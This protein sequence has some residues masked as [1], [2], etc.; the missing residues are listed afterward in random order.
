MPT[1]DALDRPASRLRVRLG[2]AL[3]RSVPL[4][5][6]LLASVQPACTSTRYMTGVGSQAYYQ[7]AWPL[8]DTSRQIEEIF[9][10]VKRIQVTGYYETFQFAPEDRVTRAAL[11]DADTYRRA[12]DRFAFDH[13]KAGTATAIARADRALHLMTNAHVTRM[14]DTVV[15]YFDST[16]HNGRFIES[17]AILRSQSNVIV[18]VPTASQFRVIA[19]DTLDDIALLRVELEPGVPEHAVPALRARAGDPG[20]LSW[21]SFVYVV[22]YPRGHMMVTRAIVSNPRQSSDNSF[23]LD[24]LFNR[25]ISGG[26]VL[27][28]RGD[29]GDLEWVGLAMS[30]SAHA[31][32]VLAPE[33]RSIDEQGVLLPYQGRLF[34]EEVR[35]IDYGITF[36]VPATAVT[37]FLRAA[38][39]PVSGGGPS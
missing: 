14:Q 1:P 16:A 28:V 18:G 36:S 25:G 3:R 30:A 7:T 23:M 32:V 8:H 39:M 34:I 22:G 24:G 12:R 26:L 20:R 37:R 17:V 21:G 35:R 15:A 38:R 19:S 13:A 27:A 29:T 33:R 31:E 5:A 6:A 2:A 4:A 11:R 9:R 10:S